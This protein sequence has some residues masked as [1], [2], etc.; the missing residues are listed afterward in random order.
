MSKPYHEWVAK[1]EL[2]D[3]AIG[4]V[5][6]LQMELTPEE[7]GLSRIRSVRRSILLPF[8][9]FLVFFSL[10]LFLTLLAV[11]CAFGEI[12]IE[13]I[14][15]GFG[16]IY[17]RDRWAPLQV[18]ITSQ[19]EAFRGEINVEVLNLFSDELIQS[20]ATP[21]TLTRTDR[22]RRTLYIFLPGISTKL[23]LKLI[24]QAGRV[25]VS[26]EIIPELPKQ[27][28]D[29]TVLA[30]TPG[31]DLLSRWDGKPIGEK[32]EGHVCVAYT[33]SRHLPTGWKGYDSVDLFILRGVS[34]SERH[35]S[36][37]QRTALLD[38]TQRG[39]TLLVSGG[40]YFRYVRGSFLEPFLPVN[41]VALQRAT[42]LSETIGRFGFA[43]EDVSFDL[44]DFKRNLGGEI[45]IGDEDRIYLAKKKLGGGGIISLAFDY[46]VPP[47]S[48]PPGVEDFWA[49]LLKE[50]GRSPRLLEEARY[51]A[52][53]RH[54]EKIQTLL[55]T[56]PSTR[57]PLIR[58]LAGFLFVYLLGIGGL[59]W[60]VGRRQSKS[61]V[62][63]ICG[64]LLPVLLS[65]VLMIRRNFSPGPVSVNRFAILSVYPE[66][67]RAHVQTYIG[68]IA[69][70]D[71]A[72]SIRFKEGTFIKPLTSTPPLRLVEA[73]DFHQ[74]HQAALDAW[75]TRAY[76][77]ESFI[78]F[79]SFLS[80]PA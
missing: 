65:C 49:W 41:L 21:L 15:L 71:L 73:K 66:R 19:N 28:I 26:Q 50:A 61:K 30:L 34:L 68:I 52:Y 53:R 5:L 57:A 31:R 43:S 46:S 4:H 51:G 42:H 37:S 40:R 60:W 48:D 45:L 55:T 80:F 16:G 72:T 58:F 18:T 56:R 6:N 75:V 47:F 22:Q 54:N 10:C 36:R 79:P 1:L 67:E 25:R 2:K 64:A 17:K 9:C 70:A 35:L 76:F 27:S 14:E 78:D 59:T 12:E 24:S 29:L 63:W 32:E 33:D 39:G 23:I 8:P 13:S 44:M 3:A 77:A 38:W 20:Y 62:Y 69:A 7:T 74:L 11:S